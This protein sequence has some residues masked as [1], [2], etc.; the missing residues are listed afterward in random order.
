MERRKPKLPQ[1]YRNDIDPMVR[2]AKLEEQ[3]AALM[4]QKAD[5]PKRGR[6]PKAQS[7]EL[8]EPQKQEVND[9]GTES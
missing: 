8:E 6:P 4:S 2:L 1:Q 3:V 5:A 9:A 7:V